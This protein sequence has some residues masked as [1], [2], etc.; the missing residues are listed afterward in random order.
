[1][2]DTAPASTEPDYY[3]VRQA[4]KPLN[5]SPRAIYELI[6]GGQLEAIQVRSAL[7]IRSEAI[8]AYLAAQPKDEDLCEISEAARR[9]QVHERTISELIADGE[10]TAVKKRGHRG[11]LIV[12]TSLDGYLER[13]AVGAQ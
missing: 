1:M 2:P 9:L 10:I 13:A 3:T 12:R 4:A 7:R 5:L 11:R 6:N 8:K